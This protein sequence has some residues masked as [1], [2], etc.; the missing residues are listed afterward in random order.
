MTSATPARRP[1]A[2][3]GLGCIGGSLAR[4]L[5]AQGVDV[6]GWSTSTSDRDLAAEAGIRIAG[7]V[8]PLAELCE[9]TTSVVLA[10][11]FGRIAEVARAVLEVALPPTRI[12]HVG[13]LQRREALGA[14]EA[15]WRGVVGTHPLSG[16][17][18]HGF[19]ASRANMFVG[20][21]VCIE[22][23]LDLRGRRA[24]EWL[25]RTAGAHRIDYR[26]ASDHDRLMAWVSHLPQLT[27]TALA[28]TMAAADVAPAST[29]SGARDTTRLAA[30]PLGAWPLLL[31]GAPDE[32][33]A[34][35]TQLEA[36]IATLR[37]TLD[38]G[39]DKELAAMWGRAMNW[40][41][42]AAGGDAGERRA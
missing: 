6:R 27:A 15:T 18:D 32:L 5:V 31:R 37:R 8:S 16:S 26:P 12:F 35:L 2:I 42:E 29:G 11:P 22:D 10:V 33:R 24:A 9:G 17:H 19:A 4:A 1:V 40:R 36:A 13:G 20:A 39:D 3:V 34:A 7:G 38:A 25:W 28:H 14:D 30:T 41:R 23:R 21:T